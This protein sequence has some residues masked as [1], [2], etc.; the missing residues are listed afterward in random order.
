[1]WFTDDVWNILEQCW[2]ARPADRPSIED[3]FWCLEKVSRSWT[4]PSPQAVADSQTSSPTWNSGPN[5]E[6]STNGG[7]SPP[8]FSEEFGGILDRVS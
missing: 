2:K 8:S 3:V 6:E 5:T 4:P 7:E 1:M